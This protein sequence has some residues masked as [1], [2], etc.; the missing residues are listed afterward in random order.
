M[1][2]TMSKILTKEEAAKASVDDLCRSH[3]ELRKRLQ[4]A[5][6]VCE[7]AAKLNAGYR[8]TYCLEL[9]RAVREW[10]EAKKG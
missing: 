2:D 3:E 5:E 8:Q 9:H 7:A 6:K 10:E 1:S 4:A